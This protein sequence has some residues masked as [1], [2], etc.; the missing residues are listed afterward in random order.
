MA[1][2]PRCRAQF[3]TLDDEEGMHDCPSCGLSPAARQCDGCGEWF[4]RRTR[5]DQACANCRE[6]EAATP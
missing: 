4:E 1:R 6:S 3:S 2:C 5:S